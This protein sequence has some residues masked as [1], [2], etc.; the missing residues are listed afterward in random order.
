[1]GLIQNSNMRFWWKSKSNRQIEVN[2]NT[3]SVVGASWWREVCLFLDHSGIRK[4]NLQTGFLSKF[5]WT[6]FEITYKQFNCMHVPMGGGRLNPF[7]NIPKHRIVIPIWNG[8]LFVSKLKKEFWIIRRCWNGL[9]RSCE[10]EYE[11]ISQG[12]YPTRQR[13]A[14]FTLLTLFRPCELT[15]Q[16]GHASDGEP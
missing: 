14:L 10:V 15:G 12:W 9:Q 6:K 4:T 7:W 3:C 11:T 8:S 13:I 5:V 2:T 1:M 16:A